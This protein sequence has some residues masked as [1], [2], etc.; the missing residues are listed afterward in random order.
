MTRT[1]RANMN[2]RTTTQRTQTQTTR[3]RTMTTRRNGGGSGGGSGGGHQIEDEDLD[4]EIIRNDYCQVY[5]DTGL[6]PQNFIHDIDLASR[7]QDY[8]K[9]E[10]VVKICSSGMHTKG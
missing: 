1:Q 2:R 5:V 10:Q 4:E 6:R 8:R 3:R 9:L 7:Y